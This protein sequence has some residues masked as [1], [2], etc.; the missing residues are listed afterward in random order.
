MIVTEIIT[1][2]GTQFLYTYSDSG[3]T[4]ER[5]GIQ[6]SEAIDPIDSNRTYTECDEYVDSDD[7][8]SNDN[9]HNDGDEI[10]AE[11]FLALIEEA[12]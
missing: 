2:N 3:K 10:S 6:Y 4:I 9:E 7:I 11:E 1:E 5:D 8:G 12:L